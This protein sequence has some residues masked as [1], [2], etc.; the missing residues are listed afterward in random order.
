MT[1]NNFL[2]SR[3]VI[4]FDVESFITEVYNKFA[5]TLNEEPIDALRSLWN[6]VLSMPRGGD[7]SIYPNAHGHHPAMLE[8]WHMAGDFWRAGY[9]L[10]DILYCDQHNIA[11][12][13]MMIAAIERCKQTSREATQATTFNDRATG[14]DTDN[15]TEATEMHQDARNDNA[16]PIQQPACETSSE[17]TETSEWDTIDDDDDYDYDPGVVV[18]TASSPTPHRRTRR[19]AA[20][21]TVIGNGEITESTNVPSNFAKSVSSFF[22]SKTTRK[23]AGG[24]G[25]VVLSA[26]IWESGLIIPFALFGGLAGGFI[27]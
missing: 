26:L 17:A 15:D 22:K 7:A 1:T 23:I 3:E 8:V 24:I 27:K 18:P 6:K 25:I 21:S 19:N 14:A 20:T 5:G 4:T 2:S 10:G 12:D 11:L 9:R 16:A 13:S